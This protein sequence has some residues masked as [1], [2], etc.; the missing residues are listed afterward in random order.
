LSLTPTGQHLY[1]SAVDM[2]EAERKLREAMNHSR[3]RP[4]GKLKVHAQTAFGPLV[5]APFCARFLALHPEIS[6]ELCTKPTKDVNLLAEGID[7]SVQVGE[8]AE[9]CTN[10]QPLATL[11]TVPVIHGSLLSRMEGPRQPSDLAAL[12]WLTCAA[13]GGNAPI[14]MH[15][16]DRHA[17]VIP[18][19]RMSTTDIGAHK[20]A[21][22]AGGGGGLIYE[23]MVAQELVEGRLVRLVPEWSLAATPVHL[24]FASANKSDT[25]QAWCSDLRIYLGAARWP[26]GSTCAPSLASTP[27]ACQRG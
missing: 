25:V 13:M 1:D 10:V 9:G 24:V 11:V 6:L 17:K 21:L 4:A 26:D 14:R 3:S 23:C 18:E 12:P 5:V 27:G 16:G 2:L 22:I 15:R 19:S 7:V 20:E 8:L